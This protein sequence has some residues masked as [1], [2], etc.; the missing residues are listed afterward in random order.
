MVFQFCGN[1]PEILLEAALLAEAHCDAVDINLGCPQAIAKRG[2]YGAFLQDD[3]QLLEKIGKKGNQHFI[4]KE[5][6]CRIYI[7]LNKS[8]KFFFYNIET[9]FFDLI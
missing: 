7:Y 3:W 2:H 1:D 9:F 5:T 6:F 8:D 4:S